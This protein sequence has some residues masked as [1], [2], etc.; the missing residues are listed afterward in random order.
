MV[1]ENHSLEIL[2]EKALAV[3]AEIPGLEAFPDSQVQIPRLL[4]G[5]PSNISGL[6]EGKF[7]DNL[8]NEE[9]EE[10]QVVLFKMTTTRALWRP[11]VP[12]QGELPLCKSQDAKE[13]IHEFYQTRCDIC[14]NDETYTHQECV[15]A[16]NRALCEH[17]KFKG[18]T[19]PQCRLAYHLLIVSVATGDPYILT[20]TGKNLSPTN[21]LLSAFKV[22]GRAPYSAS[23][24]IALKKATDGNY[25]TLEYSGLNWFESADDLKN[26]FARYKNVQLTP[27]QE[28]EKADNGKEHNGEQEFAEE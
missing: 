19:R 21:K 9:F 1:Q 15:D 28:T 5:Q 26:L 18:D 20:I 25:Y 7:I 8:T 10:L 6:P 24:R 2:K 22:R 16:N 13:P 12:Q 14:V 11:G 27:G 3:A 17:A 4:I 23:F